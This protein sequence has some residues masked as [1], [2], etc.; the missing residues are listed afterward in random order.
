MCTRTPGKVGPE[1]MKIKPDIIADLAPI[2]MWEVHLGGG[3]IATRPTLQ[4][5]TH[6]YDM[7]PLP[8]KLVTDG[9]VQDQLTL[10]SIVGDLIALLCTGAKQGTIADLSLPRYALYWLA[11]PLSSSHLI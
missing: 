2:C 6:T 1:G 8:V 7:A 3:K 11:L 5:S 9:T 10:L 4:L